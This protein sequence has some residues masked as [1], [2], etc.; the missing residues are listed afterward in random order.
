MP[1]GRAT[2]S[3]GRTPTPPKDCSSS[4]F[5]R[6]L[7]S[8]GDCVQSIPPEADLLAYSDTAHHEIY[9][10]KGCVLACQSHPEFT[11]KVMEEKIYPEER[12]WLNEKEAAEYRK[13]LE[14]ERHNL[15]LLKVRR[16][17][18][19]RQEKTFPRI[20]IQ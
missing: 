17:K 7:E 14:L 2:F 1:S 8:H 11:T 6:I 15:P 5:F 19:N 18:Y 9:E 20:F 4:N 13:S 10:W 3:E 16:S 12:G